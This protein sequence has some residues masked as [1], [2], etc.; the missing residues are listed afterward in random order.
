[1]HFHGL[2]VYLYQFTQD[3][4]NLNKM[5]ASRGRPFSNMAAISFC[6]WCLGCVYTI[7]HLHSNYVSDGK[8]I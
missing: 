8:L 1:M 4:T 5:A 2:G 3:I 6:I 7:S